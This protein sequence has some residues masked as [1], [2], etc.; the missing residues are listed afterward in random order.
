[1]NFYSITNKQNP[2]TNRLFSEACSLRKIT[3]HEIDINEYLHDPATELTY[4]DMVYRVAVD[5]RA[6]NLERLL[7]NDKT[8][9]LF[10][11]VDDVV[12]KNL[13]NQ[14]TAHQAII[15]QRAGLPIPKT[16]YS[17]PRNIQNIKPYVIKH[18]G[19]PPYIIKVNNMSQGQGV[20]KLDSIPSLLSS[21][22]YLFSH[23]QNFII[24]EFIP[25]T[26][27]ARLIVL[28]K[29]IISSLQFK[30]PPHDFR[31][32]VLQHTTTPMDFSK[33]IEQT[34]QQAVHVLGFEFGAVD[35]LI[36]DKAY[37]ISEVNFPCSFSKA[38][39][40]T[41]VDIA[42]QVIDYLRIK[43]QRLKKEI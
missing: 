16:I 3:Y 31:S 38:Q 15:H 20:L 28:G 33:A 34:A 43:S 7:I 18:L 27:S 5:P 36:I 13:T 4:G 29:D 10:Q 22:D 17:L 2:L 14:K 25:V 37:Y 32:N 35:I 6:T 40:V 1:M 21:V 24:R 9:T 26:S 42:G 11:S 19:Q 41:K 8:A 30:A 12:Y 23:N 39:S